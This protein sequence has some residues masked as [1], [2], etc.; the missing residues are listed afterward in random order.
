MKWEETVIN[1]FSTKT[2]GS[3]YTSDLSSLSFEN[4]KFNAL[5]TSAMLAKGSVPE[6]HRKVA[7][8]YMIIKRIF[9]FSAVQ[10]RVSLEERKF[11]AKFDFNV[12]EFCT[13]K[14][15]NEELAFL[16][17]WSTC[18]DENLKMS[19]DKIIDIR[20]KELRYLIASN[21][22]AITNEMYNGY[23]ALDKYFEDISKYNG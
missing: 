15:I 19:A 14:Q 22:V 6:S 9:G 21:Y 20:A 10:S 1:K 7:D 8:S 12:L 5:S 17:K 2:K 4:D 18:N 3:L 23:K 13:I 11:L 16:K